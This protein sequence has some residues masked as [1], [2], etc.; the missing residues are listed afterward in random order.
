MS[1]IHFFSRNTF[2]ISCHDFLITSRHLL[3]AMTL[4]KT[5]IYTH[6]LEG[7]THTEIMMNLFEYD[8]VDCAICKAKALT[9]SNLTLDCTHEY[10]IPCLREYYRCLRT[11]GIEGMVC[12]QCRKSVPQHILDGLWNEL[13]G[14]SYRYNLPLHMSADPSLLVSGAFQ[15]VGGREVEFITDPMRVGDL[16][17]DC[18]GRVYFA[19]YLEV[20]LTDPEIWFA[21]W[22]R[23]A[24]TGARLGP[25]KVMRTL[26]LDDPDENDE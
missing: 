16:P 23:D 26:S 3:I 9:K 12:P 19:T 14:L 25:V 5:R 8:E 18:L 7:Y 13:R 20:E 17:K 22:L 15:R 10:H 11:S 21:A 2:L 6:S 1:A 24:G 4:I